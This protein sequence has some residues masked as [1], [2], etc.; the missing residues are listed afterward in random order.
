[1]LRTLAIDLGTIAMGFC[2]RGVRSGSYLTI[3]GAVGI[4][5]QGVE[6][7]EGGCQWMEN[8]E[9]EMLQVREDSGYTDLKRFLLNAG[10]GGTGIRGSWR[11][12][13]LIRN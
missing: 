8:Y 5:I 9:E 10:Q 4:Y 12:R 6:N 1:M 2:N 13:D 11:M 7:V 3:A